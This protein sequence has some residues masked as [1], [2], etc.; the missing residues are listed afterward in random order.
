MGGSQFTKFVS[1]LL[2]LHCYDAI[3]ENIINVYDK[4][5]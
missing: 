4:V 2:K 3:L 5:Y 1:F